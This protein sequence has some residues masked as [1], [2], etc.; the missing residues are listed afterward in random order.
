[1]EIKVHRGESKLQQVI[2]IGPHTI[3]AAAPRIY[4]GEETG[5]EQHDLLAAALGTCTALMAF[6]YARR[7]GMNLQDI[8]ASPEHKQRDGVYVLTRCI[9]YVG[10]LSDEEQDRL[11][12]I[13]KKCPLHKTRSG[14]IQIITEAH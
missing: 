3:L 1:M 12:E 6:M 9:Y 2:E 8:D 13:A 4:G 11:T 7:D 5:P 10:D 14:P